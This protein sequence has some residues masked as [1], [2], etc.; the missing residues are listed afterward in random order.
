MRAVRHSLFKYYDQLEWAEKF[1]EGEIFFRSL[2]YFRDCEDEVRG[3]EYEGTSK[4]Q[5]ESGLQITNHTRGTKFT[6][7]RAFE[8]SVKADEIFV[9]C[10]S[11][12]LS[13]ALAKEFKSSICVEI[14]KIKALYN[15]I[16]SA[17]PSSATFDAGAVDYYS[18]GDGPTPRWALPEM[19]AKSKLKW[20]KPQDEYRFVFSLTGALKFE[21]V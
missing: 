6:D 14:R 4:F 19:I 1:L 20:W 9:F 18:A 17:L 2:S 8:A 5:P 12:R 10:S 13:E 15:R 3:D 16:K 11:R 7:T 21:N